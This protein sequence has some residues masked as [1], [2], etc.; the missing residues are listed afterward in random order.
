MKFTISRDDILDVMANVQGLTG[1]KS[2]LAITATILI[3]VKSD[4]IRV[5]ATDLETGF[6]G[7]YPAQIESEGTIALNSRKLFEI[8]RDFPS[9]KN[10][11]CQRGKPLGRYWR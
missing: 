2:S 5:S 7:F 4:R 1:R 8:V 6:E 3:Q 9:Q 10:K 11:F